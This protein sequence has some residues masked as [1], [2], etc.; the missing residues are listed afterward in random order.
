MELCVKMRFCLTDNYRPSVQSD[1]DTFSSLQ[2]LLEKLR[3]HRKP[4]VNELNLNVNPPQRT[5]HL[6]KE[7]L[8]MQSCN[9]YLS[10]IYFQ[11]KEY[12]YIK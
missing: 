9:L 3:K 8:L 5:L 4:L 11:I 7:S 6:G 1:I 2:Q 10:I 12:I